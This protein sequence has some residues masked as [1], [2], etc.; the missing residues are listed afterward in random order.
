[1][2]SSKT[3]RLFV[4][5]ASLVSIVTAF[6]VFGS[7]QESLKPEIIGKNI[8]YTDKTAIQFAIAPNTVDKNDVELVFTRSN[9][10]EVTLTDY[11]ETTAVINGISGALI[12][13]IEGVP[14]SSICD[15]VNVVVKS[16]GKE[17]TPFTYSVAEYFFERL[18]SDGIINATP[19]DA[20]ASRQK[21]L[22][23]N[24][25]AYA[26]SAQE[27]FKNYYGTQNIP[28]VSSYSYIGG[29]GAVFANG[30]D[31]ML[32]SDEFVT[33]ITAN[34]TLAAD[35]AFNGKW[36]VISYGEKITETTVTNGDTVSVS[37]PKAVV[38]QYT[39]DT[40]IRGEY[41]YSD[42]PGTRWD[43]DNDTMV[44][45]D[46]IYSAGN[47]GAI[48]ISD[49]ALLLDDGD[50]ENVNMYVKFQDSTE[51]SCAVFEF[52]FKLKESLGGYPIIIYIADTRHI[53]YNEDGLKIDAN[54]TKIPLEISMNQ[55][56]TLRLEHYYS[57]K[58]L[59]VFVNNEFF[60]DINTSEGKPNQ[61][62]CIYLTGNERKTASD[63]DLYIDNVYA[64]NIDKTFVSGDPKAQAN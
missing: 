14:A 21:S 43:F 34:E 52:D 47:K 1:M 11:E 56:G 51:G 35:K 25:L 38:P 8:V 6:T 46:I 31:S 16:C 53:I 48:V 64:G 33:T 2:I 23:E 40:D 57:E 26:E 50:A 61:P 62:G 17:S 12:F 7:A 45:S 39:E 42:A 13:T 20:L 55:W 36:T 5:L 19:E 28:L 59:K 30:N 9:G 3:L 49:G 41:F 10:T 27:L 63:A 29:A 44:S 32:S 54:G 15:T 18:Y 58:V 60:V 24:Y 22:Y 37:G 4:F